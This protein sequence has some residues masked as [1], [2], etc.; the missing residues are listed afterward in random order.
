MADMRNDNK[1]KDFSMF[2]DWDKEASLRIKSKLAEMGLSHKLV[3]H[4]IKMPLPTF[5]DKIGGKTAWKLSEIAKLCIL[6][7]ETS[8]C[9]IYGNALFITEFSQWSAST[10]KQQI[11]DFLIK[12]KQYETLGKMTANGYFEA[13]P[14]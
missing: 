12:N 9:I 13:E 5:N 14:D 8:D 10:I 2:R 7:G 6:I 4:L 3:A 1:F 11:K